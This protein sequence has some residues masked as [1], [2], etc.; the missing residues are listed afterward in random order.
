MAKRPAR[1][2]KNWRVRE[3]EVLRWLTEE[4]DFGLWKSSPFWSGPTVSIWTSHGVNSILVFGWFLGSGSTWIV[5]FEM[6]LMFSI[7]VLS[8]LSKRLEMSEPYSFQV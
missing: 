5:V 1:G 2:G 4:E 6:S 3:K 8:V 7:Y